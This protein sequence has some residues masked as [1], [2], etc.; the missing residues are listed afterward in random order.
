MLKYTSAGALA[1]AR[2]RDEGGGQTES[3]L[4]LAADPA[5]NVYAAGWAIGADGSEDGYLLSYTTGGS[6]RWTGWFGDPS[7]YDQEIEGVAVAGTRLYFA[8]RRYGAPADLQC[9]VGSVATAT[10]A[11]RWVGAFD[12]GTTYEETWPAAITVVPGKSVYVAAGAGA[13]DTFDGVALRFAP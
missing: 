11:Q 3:P 12:G 7:G 1:W 13:G 2:V 4:A 6:Y 9:A 5:G 10:G 8:A